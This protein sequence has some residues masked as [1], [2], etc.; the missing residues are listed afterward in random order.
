MENNPVIL[1]IDGVR[2]RVNGVIADW[3]T[4]WMETDDEAEAYYISAILNS[5]SVDEAIKPMQTRGAFGERDIV[6]ASG[7]SHSKFNPNNQTHLRFSQLSK[8]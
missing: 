8:E 7:M 2:I 6:K 4:Y 1:N 3:K 5:P